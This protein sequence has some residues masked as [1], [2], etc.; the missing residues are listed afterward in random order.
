MSEKYT[1]AEVCMVLDTYMYFNY[2]DAP[3]GIRLKDVIN[4]MS[5][6][7]IDTHPNEYAVLKDAVN[8]PQLGDLRIRYQA[9]QLGYNS[10]TNAVTF[11]NKDF[12][13][14]Y[15]AY[16]GTYDGEWYDNGQGLIK[17]QTA[18]QREAVKYFD[19]VVEHLNID[20]TTELY[21]TGHS[22]AGNK[23]QYVTMDSKY[24]DKIT[25]TYSVDGQGHSEAA[26]NRWKNAYTK[27]EYDK[28]VG[29]IYAINGENDFISVLGNSIVLASHVSY[30][31]TPVDK[32]NIA[33]Y[34]DITGMFY[35]PGDGKN[36]ATYTGKRN[37]YVLKR[38]TFANTI[39]KL[40]ES[41][42]KMNPGKREHSANTLMQLVES[43][44]GGLKTGLNGEKASILDFASFYQ[45]GIP[46]ILSNI[47]LTSEGNSFLKDIVF[48]DG[49]AD[50]VD[51]DCIVDVNYLSLRALAEEMDN[52]S[53][54]MGRILAELGTMGAAV[55]LYFDGYSYRRP[56]I[57]NSVVKLMNEKNKLRRISQVECEISRLYEE[58]DNM[59]FE[60]G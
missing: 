36:P 60:L 41:V 31:A 34:H 25:A 33:K 29:K 17:E 9:Q 19:E 39:A 1:E 59:V 55:P 52:T 16:R 46:I 53:K 51:C 48:N 26:I 14:V 38:G 27:E 37:S 13:K 20:D 3:D 44:N 54:S 30:V 42:M 12:D 6:E 50:T 32:F 23:V 47:F 43:V 28:R 5:Q 21:T 56:H 49:F 11:V 4:S 24:S 22:K 57:E 18:Q 40:S 35:K 58:F 45:E 8:S 2:Y 15:V 10:G 7:M